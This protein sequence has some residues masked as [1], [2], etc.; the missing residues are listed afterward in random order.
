MRRV[1]R[2]VMSSRVE[3][4]LNDEALMTNDEGMTKL[5]CRKI[6]ILGFVIRI[7]FVIPSFGFRHFNWSFLNFV[8]VSCKFIAKHTREIT[9]MQN[10]HIGIVLLIIVVLPSFVPP[11]ETDYAWPS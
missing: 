5:E 4:S 1:R 2:L 6:P 11:A 9:V 7:S 3:T 10:D 8:C